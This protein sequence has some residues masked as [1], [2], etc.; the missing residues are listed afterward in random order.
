MPH[1]K[2]FQFDSSYIVLIIVCNLIVVSYKTFAAVKVKW[3]CGLYA[4]Y[5]KSW[6]ELKLTVLQKPIYNLQLKAKLHGNND[7]Q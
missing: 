7:I 3:N 5:Q 2:S 4:N 1:A 6:I